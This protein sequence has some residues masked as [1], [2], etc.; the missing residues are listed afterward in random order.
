MIT[1]NYMIS[2]FGFNFNRKSTYSWFGAPGP[3]EL[4]LEYEFLF[5]WNFLGEKWVLGN[6]YT[7]RDII[8]SWPRR[9][10]VEKLKYKKYGIFTKLPPPRIHK[11]TCPLDTTGPFLVWNGHELVRDRTINVDCSI[12]RIDTVIEGIVYLLQCT[13]TA[14]IK[15]L[16]KPLIM[17]FPFLLHFWIHTLKKSGK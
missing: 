14:F 11:S 6:N 4:F 16:S 7:S 8:M 3:I 1:S 2:Y 5:T 10:T 15:S 9:I 17:K 12:E 13:Y